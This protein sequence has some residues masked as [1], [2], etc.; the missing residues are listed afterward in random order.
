MAAPVAGSIFHSEPC[1]P[2]AI[3]L[4]SGDQQGA[5]GVAEGA[6]GK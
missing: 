6:G 2:A 3:H 5:Q 4:S 1:M